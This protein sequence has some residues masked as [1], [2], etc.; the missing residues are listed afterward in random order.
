MKQEKLIR[1][2]D[3]Q[4]DMYE[5]NSNNP[6]LSTWRK[7]IIKDASG[8]VLE[9]GI[10]TGANFFHYDKS[11]VEEVIGVDFSFEMI[12][13]AEQAARA[14]QLPAKFIQQDLDNLYLESNSVDSIVSTLT[15]CG[16]PDPITTLNKYN[17]WCRED[18]KLLFM[19]HSL[20]SNSFLSV[21]QKVVD[22]LCKKIAGCHCNRDIIN[23]I[24]KS[25]LQI[26]KVERYWSG[27]LCLIWA[28]PKK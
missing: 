1:K 12:K 8:R 17:D 27:I 15:V 4:A 11:K 22:P 23:L 28:K 7:K 13:R 9:V 26:E 5:K 6:T 21:T 2:F 10:G 20:S 24:D 25:D 14:N 3:R 16:Y 18:G 19:E